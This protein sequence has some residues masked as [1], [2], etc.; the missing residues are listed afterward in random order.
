MSMDTCTMLRSIIR[1]RSVIMSRSDMRERVTLFTCGVFM[2]WRK[3]S[4]ESHKTSERS[5]ARA[6]AVRGAEERAEISPNCSPGPA[7]RVIR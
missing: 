1:A 6:V 3:E 5:T 7:L 2:S 4:G